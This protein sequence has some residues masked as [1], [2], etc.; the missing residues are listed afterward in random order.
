MLRC[1]LDT[2]FNTAISFRTCS[3]ESA[4]SDRRCDPVLS[5]K[6]S[7]SRTNHIFPPFHELLVDNLA[8]IVFSCLDMNRFLYDGVCAATEGFACAILIV[9]RIRFSEGADEKELT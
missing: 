7:R 3:L 5:L 8:S 2:F 4:N 9:D 6:R 1:P